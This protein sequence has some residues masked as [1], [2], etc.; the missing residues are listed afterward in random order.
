MLNPPPIPDLL[1]ELGRFRAM[2]SRLPGTASVD[3]LAR[4]ATDAWSLTEV[5]CHLRDVEREVHQPRLR[6]IL[7]EENAF[8]AGVDAD[9]WASMRHY[10]A[11]DGI[12]ATR[13]FLDLRDETLTLLAGLTTEEWSRRGQHSFFGPTT[14]QELVYLAVQHDRVHTRQLA[15]L[16]GDWLTS[17]QTIDDSPP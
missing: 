16:T 10:Q 2:V 13:E 5:A 4:P 15:A 9:E 12:T 14:L 7:A 3:W 11:Q 8:I 6:A 1:A 17:D